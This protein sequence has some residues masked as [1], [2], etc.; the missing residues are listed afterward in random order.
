M[1]LSPVLGASNKDF[2]IDLN[3]GIEYNLLNEDGE[4][5]SNVIGVNLRP[6][7]SIGNFGIGLT[8]A[9]RFQ[10]GTDSLFT[11]IAEDWVP[12]YSEDATLYEQIQTTASLY[13]PVFRYVRYGW[14]GDPLYLRLGE[15]DSVTIG[16][17][18]FVNQYTNT[19]LQPDTRLMGAEF[20]LDGEL[21]GFPYIGFETFASDLALLDVMAGRLYIRPLAFIDF[22]V[23][24]TLQFGGSYAVDRGPDNHDSEGEFTTAPDM[25]QM[26][27]TDVMMPILSSSFL[28]MTL[29][30]DMAFQSSPQ[31]E[32]TKAYRAGLMGRI[33]GFLGYNADVTFP[34]E[35][36]IPDYFGKN[37]D[38]D[39]YVVYTSDGISSDD[40]YLHAGAGFNFFDD[41]LVFD[42]NITGNIEA[43][44]DPV[45]IANPSMIA[46]LKLGEDILP[47]FFFD[48]TYTKTQLNGDSF[49][50]FLDD[51]L[52]PTVNSEIYADVTISYK[53]IETTFGYTITFD[54]DGNRTQS[55]TAAGNLELPFF[56]D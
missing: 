34:E 52:N 2:D 13:L 41:N 1:V 42:L 53:V 19:A 6:D 48:A 15:L 33:L 40:I 12:D 20:D 31:E 37:Y 30:G 11:F 27:G 45:Q 3:L 23:L 55:L 51:V 22:P 43:A 39:R 21:V 38:T 46:H 47:F 32:L 26:Y 28:R 35:G 24:N 56:G 10:I 54:S 4:E 7:I 9:L 29:F 18:I 49:D 5:S 44:E 50:E 14:K 8:G 36:F 17:G 16:T 25:V